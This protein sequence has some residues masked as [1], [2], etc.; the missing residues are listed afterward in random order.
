MSLTV[1]GLSKSYGATPALSDVTIDVDPAELVVIV[2]PSGSGK[3]TL[4]RCVAG[5]EQ[6]DGGT[7]EVAGRDVTKL[8]PGKRDVAMIFQDLAL[9]PHLEVRQNI[10]FPLLAQRLSKD[11]VARKVETVALSLGLEDLLERRPQDLSGG[12]RRRVAI[13]RAIIRE[14]QLFLMDEPLSNLDAQLKLRVQQELADLPRRLGITTVYVTHDQAEA[15][16]LGQRIVVMKAGSVEQIGSPAEIYDLPKT[17]WVA[18]FFGRFPMNVLPGEVLGAPGSLKAGVRPEDVA[19]TDA[20][21]GRVRGVVEQVEVLGP[22]KLIV[23]R[24]GEETLRSVA[25]RTCAA[26]PGDEVGLTFEDARLHRFDISG[27]RA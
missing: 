26:V 5:L 19:L 17:E 3:S 24:V 22:D 20:A 14:P 12:E 15:M 11:V 8:P 21:S 9:Y 6:A 10:A 25:A 13:A 1:E 7:V 16:V 27:E 23:I 2:G 4:L 18:R